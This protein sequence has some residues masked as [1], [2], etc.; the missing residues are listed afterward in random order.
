MKKVE[1]EIKDKHNKI[2]KDTAPK[3]TTSTTKSKKVAVK[4]TQP[5]IKEVEEKAVKSQDL[6]CEVKNDETNA[7]FNK[8]NKCHHGLYFSYNARVW[9]YFVMFVF[10]FLFSIFCFLKIFHYTPAQ[11]IQYKESSNMNYTFKLFDDSFYEDKEITKDDEITPITSAIDKVILDF[12]YDFIFGNNPVPMNFNYDINAELIITSKDGAKKYYNKDFKIKPAISKALNG[13]NN[14]QIKENVV[15]DYVYFNDLANKINTSLSGLETNS[16]LVVNMKINKDSID[17]NVSFEI[18]DNENIKIEIPLSERTMANT[19]LTIKDIPKE[20]KQVLKKAEYSID[21]SKYL[22]YFI[23]AA[24]LSIVCI[25]RLLVLLFSVRSKKSNYDKFIKKVLKTYDRLIVETTTAP[26]FESEQIVKI[27]KFE[28]LLDVRDNIKKPIL[29]Y[30]VAEHEK[31]Y[32]FIND[33]TI[34]YVLTVKAVDLN[35]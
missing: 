1:K 21:C 11:Y 7:I 14:F 29:Y 4:K 23:V 34:L 24:F 12:Q 22:L 13:N 3:K 16:K 26:N 25:I 31:S 17:D 28:E 33:D 5:Q 30:I 15:I 2:N 32:F 20:D 9:F 19:A 10:L 27:Y 35:N 6:D 8:K 18:K